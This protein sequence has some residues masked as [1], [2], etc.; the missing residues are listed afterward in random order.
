MRY[1][2]LQGVV[3]HGGWAVVPGNLVEVPQDLTPELARQLVVRGFLVAEEAA[4]APPLPPPQKAGTLATREPEPE[5]RDPRRKPT[6][7]KNGE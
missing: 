4:P 5:H 6:A 2:V 3:I 7:T 1:R